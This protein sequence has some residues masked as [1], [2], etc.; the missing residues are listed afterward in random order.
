M[1]LLHITPTYAPRIGGVEEVVANL[2][3]V[4]RSAGI[5]AD[6]AHVAPGLT[7]ATHDHDGLS[8]MTLP[9]FG[10]RMLGWAPDLERLAS[11]YD[12]LHVH[13]PQVGAL[14]LN[15]FGRAAR[16]PAVL[17]THGGFFH[18]ASARTAKLIHARVT[19]PLLLRR[20]TRVLASSRT[21]L[22]T[23]RR[24]SSRTVLAE[25]GIDT[26]KFGTGSHMRR[27]LARWIYWGRFSRNKRLDA[28]VQ[29]IAVLAEK[30]I[31]VELSICGTDFDGTLR[32]LQSLI[33]TSRLE[34][35]IHIRTGLDDRALRAEIES[36]GVFVLPSE[37]EGFGLSLL[38]AMGAGLLPVCRDI[39]PMN[40]LAGRAATLLDFNGGESDIQR[41]CNLLSLSPE[42]ETG[43]REEAMSR[44]GSFGWKSRAADFLQHYEESIRNAR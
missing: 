23:F 12:L 17:S 18:T 27:N 37:Y 11:G 5:H 36:C 28:L 22:A 39:S 14:T 34:D 1:R 29:L 16:V 32:S 6:V 38:E 15:I 30:G 13:D 31:A 2:A 33:S 44:A 20:Y 7:R 9:L 8:V 3:R 26:T 19:A 24:Y 41:V 4:G 10:H 21:D 35:R 25:N 43:L 42:R 40:L